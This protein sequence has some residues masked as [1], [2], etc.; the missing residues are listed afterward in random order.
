MKV[1]ETRGVARPLLCALLSLLC[2]IPAPAGAAR[3]V[4][5]EPGET[6]EA[7]AVLEGGAVELADGHTVALIG[8]TVP[9]GRQPF[10]GEARAALEAMLVGQ[11]VELRFAGARLDR[12]GRVTAHLFVGKRWVEGELLRRGLAR[13]ES[14]GD[15]RLGVGE[16]LA[17][18]DKAR[19]AKRGLWRETYY[20]V[21]RAEEAGRYAGSFQLVVG[22]V[23]NIGRA[24]GALFINFA[25]DWR[26]GFSLKLT[27]E[28]LRL[29]R[30]EGIEPAAFEGRRLRVRGFVHG[31]ERPTI[32]VTHPEQIESALSRPRHGD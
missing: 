17:R 28:A 10:A 18:E 5:F 15:H 19:R 9:R 21:R 20:A 12:Y 32:D 16:L 27:P 14:T 8:V 1:C 2:A 11:P 22:K 13:V 30:A 31:V 24:D 7:R 25:D 29:F 3:P 6:A 4:P 26:H 23:A